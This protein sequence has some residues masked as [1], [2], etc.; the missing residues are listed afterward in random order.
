MVQGS[1]C[2]IS[3]GGKWDSVF[4]GKVF[5]GKNGYSPSPPPVCPISMWKGRKQGVRVRIFLLVHVK[6]K[7]NSLLFLMKYRN[8]QTLLHEKLLYFLFY[9]YC[10]SFS[11]S[12]S[13]Y[14]YLKVRVFKKN[15]EK[16]LE[17]ICFHSAQGCKLN[18]TRPP[19]APFTDL[20]KCLTECHAANKHGH[21]M[22]LASS[23][24]L[25]TPSVL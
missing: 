8:S 11:Q 23:L 24:R 19:F 25:L 17:T 7:V 1:F 22:A 3:C 14:K 9:Y 5:S 20:D 4:Y 10:Q 13:K 15:E 16:D 21:A 12:H 6:A 18:K 2:F